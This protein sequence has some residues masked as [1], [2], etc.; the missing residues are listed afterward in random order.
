L[1]DILGNLIGNF[2]RQARNDYDRKLRI[3]SGI[4]AQPAWSD[5]EIAWDNTRVHIEDILRLL[6]QGT[7]LWDAVDIYA[8]DKW[9]EMSLTLTSY[10]LQLEQVQEQVSLILEEDDRNTITWLEQKVR[11]DDLSLHAA[12]LHV[13]NLVRQ[14]LLDSKEAIVFTSATLR[15][16]NSFD[17]LKDRLGSWDV[18]EIAVGSPFNYAES[19]LLYIPTDLPEPNAPGYQKA[20]EETLIALAIATRG[21]M[22]VLFTSYN[23]LRTTARH[24]RRPLAGHDILVYQQ[25]AGASRRQLLEN[26]KTAEKAVLMGTRSFWEGV[27]VP[28]PA[29]SCV[30]IAKIPFAVPSDPIFQARSETFDNPFSQYS[31]PEAILHFRQG[32]GRLIR[33]RTDRGVV[34]IMDKRVLT[35]S[36]GRAFLDSLPEA[37]LRRGLAANLPAIAARWIDQS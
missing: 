19:T 18:H 20:F 23:Q 22:L 27:D 8:V 34:V 1:F 25:G 35:K 33:T 5:V 36:Y 37:T 15:T 9:E 16:D 10:R 21:R 11:T 6:K 13:G 32:F 31:I 14:H 28:G 2:S 17:Y 7:R 24:V 26:F 3:G 12:P 29:L 30:V 4:R